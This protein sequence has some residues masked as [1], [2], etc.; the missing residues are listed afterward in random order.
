MTAE[1][2]DFNQPIVIRIPQVGY[3]PVKSV[4]AI[5]LGSNLNTPQRQLE[6]GLARLQQQPKIEILQ[7]SPCFWTEPVVWPESSRQQ[8]TAPLPPPP[9]LNGAALLATTL[10]PQKLMQ[11]L[12]NVETAQGR[13]R[14]FKWAPRTLDLDILLWEGQRINYSASSF[15][16]DCGTVS[17]LPDVVIPHPRLHERPFA[18]VPLSY[19]VP[20]WLIP[21]DTRETSIRQLANAAGT[22]GVDIANPVK[23]SLP[24]FS[25]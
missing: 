21:G 24:H 5:A 3:D 13:T 1:P 12:L 6:A 23:L 2:P 20:D 16:N 9:Y 14:E 18:L 7:I 25:C 19:L 8:E 22:H 17:T 15:A 11:T 4:V 10:P